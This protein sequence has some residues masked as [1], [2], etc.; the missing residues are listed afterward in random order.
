MKRPSK[1]Q[2]VEIVEKETSEEQV[3]R[4]TLTVSFI[5]NEV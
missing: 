2:I 4:A 1:S 3:L 5:L